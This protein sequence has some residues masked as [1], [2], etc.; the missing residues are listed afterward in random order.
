M[1]SRDFQS[2]QWNGYRISREA[3]EEFYSFFR[4]NQI[5][6]VMDNGVEITIYDKNKEKDFPAIYNEFTS[7]IFKIRETKRKSIV[8]SVIPESES[9]IRIIG[10][11]I[12]CGD[13]DTTNHI[14]RKRC[15]GCNRKLELSYQ[16]FRW[17]GIKVNKH[18]QR[19]LSERILEKEPE[20]Q[21]KMT[22]KTRHILE[23]TVLVPIHDNHSITSMGF[24]SE[25]YEVIFPIR[26]HSHREGVGITTAIH[27]N[28]DTDNELIQQKELINCEKCNSVN[29]KNRSSCRNC[30]YKI[31]Y[32][33]I[34]N[35]DEK[36]K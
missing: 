2:R 9:E 16:S 21:E 4:H 1:G 6:K 3:Q 22:K 30:N 32:Q 35:Y 17:R 15:K 10:K 29:H 20:T 23:K 24:L 34:F 8:S 11:I 14:N 12:E 33:P 5:E 28:D 19:R 25:E 27:I 7:I 31:D 18:P 26:N 13:C 36:R